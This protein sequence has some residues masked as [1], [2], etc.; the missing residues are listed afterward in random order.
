MLFLAATCA[1]ASTNTLW[2]QAFQNLPT[3]ALLFTEWMHRIEMESARVDP[4]GIGLRFVNNSAPWNNPD[5]QPPVQITETNTVS[6]AQVLDALEFCIGIKCRKVDNL[7]V[8][9]DHQFRYL[10]LA[11]SGRCVNA[12]TKEPVTNVS[13]RAENSV[14][15][16]TFMTMDAAGRFTCGLPHKFNFITLPDAVFTD[17]GF[18]FATNIVTISAPGY[19]DCTVT[20]DIWDWRSGWG[21]YYLDVELVKK[22]ENDAN[23]YLDHIPEVQ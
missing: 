17:D 13:V 16:A 1:Y 21:G 18:P 4:V 20:N 8:I 9:G 12:Q 14:F 11:F 7:I 10:L 23:K 6:F 15:P 3:N 2:D 22:R 19:H 5:D